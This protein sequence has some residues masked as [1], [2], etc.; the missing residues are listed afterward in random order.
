MAFHFLTVAGLDQSLI[1]LRARLFVF[2][3]IVLEHCFGVLQNLQKYLE[4]LVFCLVV[5]AVE[6]I[7]GRVLAVS[8]VLVFRLKKVTNSQHFHA[9]ILSHGG[10]EHLQNPFRVVHAPEEAAEHCVRHIVLGRLHEFLLEHHFV[11]APHRVS[12]HQRQMR[13]G[14]AQ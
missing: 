6:F 9:I 3:F 14:D 13:S 5:R 8:A 2:I 4:A 12:H 10:F 1:V 11:R 7:L